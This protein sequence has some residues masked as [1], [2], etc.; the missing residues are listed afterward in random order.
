MN[1][2]IFDNEITISMKD[3]ITKIFIDRKVI[4]IIDNYMDKERFD[5]SLIYKFNYLYF[6]SENQGFLI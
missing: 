6:L 4:A 1:T 2:G 5:K 3:M